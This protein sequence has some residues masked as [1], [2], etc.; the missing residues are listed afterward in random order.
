M[1][2]T[3]VGGILQFD[4]VNSLVP[5]SRRA[6]RANHIRVVPVL[7]KCLGVALRARVESVSII[8]DD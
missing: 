4:Q 5:G 2:G 7:G 6:R 3:L 8:Y 1:P